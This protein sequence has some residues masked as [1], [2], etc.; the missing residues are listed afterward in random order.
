MDNSIPAE[1]GDLNINWDSQVGDGDGSEA[2]ADWGARE[3]LQPAITDTVSQTRPEPDQ[4]GHS[5]PSFAPR[6]AGNDCEE[7]QKNDD[8]MNNLKEGATVFIVLYYIISDG[9]HRCDV[10]LN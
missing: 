8:R 1:L 9:F 6:R 4:T 2:A 7:Q 10:P 5:G 3:G